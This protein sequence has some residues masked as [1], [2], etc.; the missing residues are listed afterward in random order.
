MTTS[1]NR[2][3]LE[4]GPAIESEMQ[5]RRVGRT[6]SYARAHLCNSSKIALA[7]AAV[8]PSMN[9]RARALATRPVIIITTQTTV[10]RGFDFNS[11]IYTS[12]YARVLVYTGCDLVDFRRLQVYL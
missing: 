12:I 10:V 6:A 1:G 7:A 3:A 9:A 4:R 2:A 11:F 8:F 5:K